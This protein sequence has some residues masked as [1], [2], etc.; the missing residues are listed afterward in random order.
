MEELLRIASR[1]VR[2]RAQ[3][4]KMSEEEQVALIEKQQEK[5][6]ALRQNCEEV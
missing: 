1:N 6:N 5:L 2:A 3:F 4:N